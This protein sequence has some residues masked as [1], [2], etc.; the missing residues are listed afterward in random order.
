MAYCMYLRK[1]RADREAEA[2]GEGETLARHEKTLLELAARMNIN[3]TKI[4]KEIVSGETIAARP[5]VQQLLSEVRHGLWEGVLVM[6]IERLARGDT[7]DQGTVTQAF[8]LSDTQIITPIKTFAPSD[9]FDEEYL[10]FNL[11]MSRREY[12]TI[13]RR[14]QRGRVRSI[15]EGKYISP[16]PPYGYDRIKIENDSGYTLQIREDQAAAVR[17]MFNWYVDEQIGSYTIATRLNEYGY[18]PAKSENWSAA[19]VR[20]I[21]A[22]PV[23]AG[24]IKWGERAEIKYIDEETGEIKKS[25][26]YSEN[27]TLVEG[28]HDGIISKDIFD[29]AQEIKKNNIISSA[30]GF[31]GLK[32]PLAGLVKCGICGKTMQRQEEK[33]RGSVWLLCATQ[34]CN[35]ASSHFEYVEEAILEGMRRWLI[36][37]KV[38][39]ALP[40][41]KQDDISPAIVRQEEELEK[42]ECQTQKLHDLL[43]QGIYDIDTFLHRQQ[44]LADK[45]ASIKKALSELEKKKKQQRQVLSIDEFLP[46]VKHVLDVY[47]VL[48]S[49]EDKNRLLKTVLQKAVYTKTE[50]GVKHMRDFEIELFP[51]LKI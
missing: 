35:C 43:E 40:H 7:K 39:P 46:K 21:L 23:Y 30:S 29:K 9:E 47:D 45:K 8:Q 6:E 16:D 19:S 20:G 36:D 5:V 10:E 24:Y 31:H 18:K 33:R 42:M 3:I 51:L 38:T 4:Y 32:S 17:L 26:P 37:L 15:L 49:P 34:N 13:N 48:E 1:S 14:I 12:K 22:N 2:R 44:I 27:F 41:A 25:R 50:K 11:F 28:L